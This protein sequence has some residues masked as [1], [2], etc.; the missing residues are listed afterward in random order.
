M[1]PWV[2]KIALVLAEGD[3]FAGWYEEAAA[4]SGL[5]VE[6]HSSSRLE[7]ALG[8]RV[9]CLCGVQEA[10]IIHRS[11]LVR[12]AAGG[13]A[14]V[15]SGSSW[16]LDTELGLVD[17]GRPDFGRGQLAA[18]ARGTIL[19]EGASQCLF[20]GGARRSE[21]LAKA[22]ARGGHGECL[23]SSHQQFFWFAPHVGRT[24]GMMAMGRA[25][26]GDAL[27]PGDG[28]CSFEDGAATAEKGT[29]LRLDEDRT[30]S[31][32]GAPWADWIREAWTRMVFLA[33]QVAGQAPIL[34]SGAPMGYQA[35]ACLSAEADPL[36]TDASRSF[37]KTLGK[38]GLRAGWLSSG[39]GLPGDLVRSLKN[40]DHSFGLLFAGHGESFCDDQLRIQMIQAG[41]PVGSSMFACS[42]PLEGGWQGWDAYY[43]MME[44][45]GAKASLSKGGRQEGT[46]GF[47]FGTC[48]P[49]FAR[50]RD[51][52]R[53]RVLE[54][55]YTALLPTA[56]EASLGV[57]AAEASRS[58]G[59]FHVAVDLSDDRV[60]V[61]DRAV[62]SLNMA[63]RQNRLL[64]LTPDQAVAY[65]L[66]VRSLRAASRGTG[67]TLV[68]EAFC[69][70]LTILAPPD[71]TLAPGTGWQE[72]RRVKR[73]GA[74]FSAWTADAQPK[75]T[76]EV[77]TTT[78][79]AA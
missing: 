76:L 24:L 1:T 5:F 67:L 3:P 40:H 55:P 29:H 70:G 77:T 11:A 48:H 45:I 25:V 50:K 49:F 37:L 63:V 22:L 17:E 15:I 79:A 2:G 72:V 19:P 75:Q 66:A 41:R 64:V 69:P 13:G 20:F 59:V 12:H 53:R 18:L 47:L 65:V 54:L 30:G 57:L 10:S 71:C 39:S 61:V 4:Q 14:V 52:A 21:S 23:A 78:R 51:G 74:D 60:E 31:Y 62:M 28:T 16:A 42:R 43:D 44:R 33:C 6:V 73:F 46:T 68:S 9:I 27:S 26:E 34:A 56:G 8:C 32:F 7:D 58:G 35:I 38:Y 36:H